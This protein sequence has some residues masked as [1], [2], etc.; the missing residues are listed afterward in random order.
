MDGLLREL[1]DIDILVNNVG[2]FELRE[3]TEISEKDWMDMFNIN[4]LSGVRL[5][6]HRS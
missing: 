6:K 1:G 2:V 4:V 5:T 3:F